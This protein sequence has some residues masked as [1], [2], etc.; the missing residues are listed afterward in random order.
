MAGYGHLISKAIA[1]GQLVGP[2]IYSAVSLISQTAGHGD[3][4]GTPL[5]YVKDL[6]NHGVPMTIADGVSEC[7]KA[8]RENIR[9]GAK[10]IKV[11]ASGGVLS[12]LDNPQDQQFSDEGEYL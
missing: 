9:K 10:V 1:E 7:R 6:C 5:E 4:H 11:A 8:V 3:A 12:E 2:N